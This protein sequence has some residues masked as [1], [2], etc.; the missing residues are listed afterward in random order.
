MLSRVQGRRGYRNHNHPPSG[1]DGKAGL[2]GWM[3]AFRRFWRGDHHS[4]NSNNH[5]NN[6]GSSSSA[7][8][9]V[10]ADHT[11]QPKIGDMESESVETRLDA[12]VLPLPARA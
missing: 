11:C 9:I 5:H 2:P 7:A 1:A 6:C 8:S 10:A 3:K 12:A 4:S